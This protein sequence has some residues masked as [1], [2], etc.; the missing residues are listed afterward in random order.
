[1]SKNVFT[2]V[3]RA[4]DTDLSDFCSPS[5]SSYF[6]V[7]HIYDARRPLWQSNLK[8]TNSAQQWPFRYLAPWRFIYYTLSPFNLVCT[9]GFILHKHQYLLFNSLRVV[10]NAIIKQSIY[11]GKIPISRENRNFL[12]IRAQSMSILAATNIP[13]ENSSAQVIFQ[14]E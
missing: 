1:M 14:C 7:L 10:R 11:K 5:L 4:S 2:E 6:S 3:K 13:S 12:P 9:K 8:N